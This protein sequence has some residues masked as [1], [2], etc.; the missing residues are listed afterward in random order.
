MALD[1]ELQSHHPTMQTERPASHRTNKTLL[2][3]QPP[4]YPVMAN[5][6]S[7]SMDTGNDTAHSTRATDQDPSKLQ[8]YYS[9]GFAWQQAPGVS[10]ASHNLHTAPISADNMLRTYQASIQP[11]QQQTVPPATAP[12]TIGNATTNFQQYAP[13]SQYSTYN[14]QGTGPLQVQ[15]S[16]YA[17]APPT[18]ATNP[19]FGPTQWYQYAPPPTAPSSMRPSLP[20]MHSVPTMSTATSYS[21]ITAQDSTGSTSG[22]PRLR[23]F[24]EL[25]QEV[26]SVPMIQQWSSAAP[27]MVRESV[28]PMGYPGTYDPSAAH[29]SL[30]SLEAG[31]LPRAGS[32]SHD[33][34]REQSTRGRE[35]SSDEEGVTPNTS[36][37]M[38]NY[39]QGSVDGRS[40]RG[41]QSVAGGS[42]KSLSDHDRDREEPRQEKSTRGRPKKKAKHQE[43]PAEQDEE[44]VAVKANGKGNQFILTLYA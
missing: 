40:R 15:Q 13:Q 6:T 9:S 34:S 22:Y 42:S 35:E 7:G 19:A 1:P 30:G 20:H 11:I 4:S 28:R 14:G 23:S 27:M 8:R 3:L 44:I 21:P 12:L 25:Q 5:T 41:R 10:Q 38:V 43:R 37:E 26:N 17:S 36:K 16:S 31:R 2:T 18:Q 32:W 33:R 39:A 29:A 24:A